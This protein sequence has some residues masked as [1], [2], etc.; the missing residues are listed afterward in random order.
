VR[1]LAGIL[2][3]VGALGT[4]Y[5]ASICLSVGTLTL[6][7]SG[8]LHPALAEVVRIGW[9]LLASAAAAVVLNL[10]LLAPSLPP[11]VNSLLVGFGLAALAWLGGVLA[12]IIRRTP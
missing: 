3:I 8:V 1:V 5:L 6:D 12:I 4:A 9:L 2:G 7:D 11:R 10:A